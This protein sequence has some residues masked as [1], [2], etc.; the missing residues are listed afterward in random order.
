MSSRQDS[1]QGQ[2]A[3]PSLD[4]YDGIRSSSTSSTSSGDYMGIPG[5][6]EK[7]PRARRK[8]TLSYAENENERDL[9]L[10]LKNVEEEKNRLVLGR[11]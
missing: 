8:R 11:W 6:A 5:S 3:N 2:E 7:N 1:G 9:Q 10:A 4:I